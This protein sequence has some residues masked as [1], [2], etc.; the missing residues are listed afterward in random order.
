MAAIQKKILIVQY[1]PRI[2]SERMASLNVNILEKNLQY[3]GDL[4]TTTISSIFNFFRKV[5]MMPHMTP[6]GHVWPHLALLATF[7]SVGS[8]WPFLAPF[9]PVWPRLTL[10]GTIWHHLAPFGPTWPHLPLL[11]H[12][13][14]FILRYFKVPIRQ[15]GQCIQVQ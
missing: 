2:S 15:G 5:P 14:I 3:Q 13:S 9:D 6:F 8:F 12:S 7:R 10:F 11:G 4:K 1:F